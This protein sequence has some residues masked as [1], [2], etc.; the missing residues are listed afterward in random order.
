MY[1]RE[2]EFEDY[3]GNQLK[4]KY[5]FNLNEAEILDWITTNGD[6]SLEAVL[7]KMVEKK[8][9]KD[10]LD[11]LRDLIYRS[12]GERGLDSRRFDKSEEAKK[13]FMES[14][15]FSVL[16]MDLVTDASK[17]AE[18]INGIIPKKMAESIAK[19]MNENPDAIP[20]SMKDY[21]TPM[22]E[23]NKNSK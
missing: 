10:I 23:S 19:T 13:A 8:R 6:Y 2:I 21:I 18:F 9:G 20:D 16:F 3:D 12:Y 22:I 4:E 15:A 1:C 5:Y 7:N 11:A 17:A 14:N